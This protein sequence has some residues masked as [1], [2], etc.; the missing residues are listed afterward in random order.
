MR[1]ENCLNPVTPRS[2]IKT[3]SLSMKSIG[4]SIPF[5]YPANHDYV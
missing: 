3:G 4:W 5:L 1:I 2:S